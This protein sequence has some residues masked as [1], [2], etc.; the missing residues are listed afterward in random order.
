M[1]AA[2]LESKGQLAVR[3]FPEPERDGWARVKTAAA[4]ICGT[5]L[6]IIDAMF[7]PPSYPFVI[8]HEAAGVVVDAPAG[9]RVSPGDRV[10]VYNMIGCG[11][12]QWCRSGNDQV[13]TDPVGQLG[14][15]LNGTFS[16]VIAVP[17][18][19]LVPLP[20]SVSFEDAALLSCGGMTAVHAVRLAGVTIGETAVV[21]GV[22][23]V[24]LMVIQVA[25]AAGARVIAV[26]DSEAKARM[27]LEAGASQSI[28]LGDEGY[29]SVAAQVR[30][31]TGGSGSSHFFELVGT[32]ASMQAG[33]RGLARHGTFVSIGYTPDEL[34]IHPIEL[35]LSESKIV[36][37]VAAGIRDLEI[38]VGLAADGRLRTIIDTRYRLDEVGV[39]LDR[40]R[41]RQVNGRNVLVWPA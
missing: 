12:C 19:N 31:A 8:G 32:E 3:E 26:A 14:F 34:R 27:A 33:L 38:A 7:E 10:A 25:R 30:G 16:D 9:S 40:L 23:G 5:E 22:G 39:G 29:E 20:D 1:K 2:V 28:V 4:G 21:D 13:C 36:S 35:I 17:P 41:A 24:G 6:H 15:T 11:H 37:S 18:E